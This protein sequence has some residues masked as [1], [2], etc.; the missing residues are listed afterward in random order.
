MT[1]STKSAVQLL[2]ELRQEREE[3]SVLI[4]ALEKRL[5]IV[6]SAFVI[7][8]DD[9]VTEAKIAPPNGA[10]PTI[11]VGVFHNLSQAAAAEKLLRMTPGR[12]YS[13]GEIMEAF[14]NSGMVLNPKNALTILYTALKRSQKFER[15]G[16]KAW[17]LKEWY[18]EKKR[19]QDQPTLKDKTDQSL[20]EHANDKD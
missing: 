4:Q 5:G 7:A 18:P 2:Q 8:V 6:E 9:D 14:K 17:G 15:V 10:L 16:N 12:A 13:T 19:K 3:L 11:Q 20:R 1:D